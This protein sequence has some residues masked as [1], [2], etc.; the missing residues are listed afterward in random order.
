MRFI[1][2]V[3]AQIIGHMTHQ[4]NPYAAQKD[5]TTSLAILIYTVCLLS[6]PSVEDHWAMETRVPQA[7]EKGR[8][9]Q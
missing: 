3:D 8:P 7:A 6:S 4:T 2:Y 1:G 5:I 9:L